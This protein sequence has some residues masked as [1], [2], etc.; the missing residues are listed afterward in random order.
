VRATARG[1]DVFAVVREFVAEVDA[2]LDARL[3]IAKVTRLRALLQELDEALDGA[4][5]SEGRATASA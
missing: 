4:A 5:R 1:E 3:G 2:R